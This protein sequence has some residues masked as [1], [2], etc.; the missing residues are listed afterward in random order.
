M[1]DVPGKTVFAVVLAA[2]Y[3]SRFGS[4]KQLAEADGVALVKRAVDAACGAC[5]RNVAVVIGHEWQS[6]S[7]ACMPFDGFLIVNDSFADGMGSSIAAAVRRLRHVAD[8]VII[9]LADQPLVT[10]EHIRSL[11]DSWSGAADEIVATAFADT[12]GPPVLFPRDC[13]DELAALQGDSGGRHLLE[14]DRFAVKRMIFEG[15]A[16]DIDN[17]AD[18]DVAVAGGLFV[19]HRGAQRSES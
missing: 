9:M 19:D 17:P 18:L 8:A 13:F 2:G 12:C 5:E 15:A 16:V 14:N 3:A 11:V 1:N 4:A 6:V 7:N 10:A